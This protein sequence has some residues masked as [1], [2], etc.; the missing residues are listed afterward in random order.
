MTLSA[1]RRPLSR[2]SFVAALIACALALPALAGDTVPLVRT[3]HFSLVV[4]GAADPDARIF[5]SK[6]GKPRLLID[7]DAIAGPLVVAVAER[8]A[9]L[10]DATRLA[11][12]DLAADRIDVPAEA[13]DAGGEG[14]VPVTPGRGGV[15]IA[16]GGLTLEIGQA[17]PLVGA[18]TADDL[19]KKLPEYRRNKA[20]Y[21]PKPAAIEAL[22]QVGEPLTVDVVFGSWCPHCEQVVPRLLSVIEKAGNP[23][24]TFRFHGVTRAF[25]A[26]PTARQFRASSL[27]TVVLSRGTLEVGRLEGPVLDVPETALV[28]ALGDE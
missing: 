5:L 8:K 15:S 4:D 21:E 16:L 1:P 13:L 19:L 9:L 20:A 17:E 23:N 22:K 28:S 24:L 12:A 27:P 3:G 14:A 18:L 6:R 26:D 25:T 11:G 2:R 7:A 10:V